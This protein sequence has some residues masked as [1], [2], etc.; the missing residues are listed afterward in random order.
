MITDDVTELIANLLSFR[1]DIIHLSYNAV[2]S[3][4]FGCIFYGII[5]FLS[6][7]NVEYMTIGSTLSTIFVKNSN[8]LF[9]QWNIKMLTC[10]LGKHFNSSLYNVIDTELK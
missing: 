2:K 9:G 8:S 1:T 6:T 3:C 7:W 10:L 5:Q 4:N